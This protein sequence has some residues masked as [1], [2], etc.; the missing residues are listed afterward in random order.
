MDTKVCVRCG[1][2]YRKPQWSHG[3][4]WAVRQYCTHA[5]YRARESAPLADRFWRYV[6]KTSGC[7]EWTASTAAGYG[8]FGL[9]RETMVGAH[10]FSWE[11]HFGPI[12]PGM[13]V[14]HHCDNKVCVRPDHLFLGTA[15]ANN[16]DMDRKGRRVLAPLHGEANPNAKL[17][18]DDVFEI[19]RLCGEG[20]AKREL[21]RRFGVTPTLIRSVVARRHWKSV[22]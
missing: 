5:C 18:A 2:T 15:L 22:P 11:L 17:T 19:R 14:C 9:D 10:R 20:I 16:R 12:P 21:A 6:R 1:T 3:R 7:W 13:Y 4:S 8:T